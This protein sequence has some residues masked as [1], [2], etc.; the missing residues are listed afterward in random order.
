MWEIKRNF[1]R[2][3]LGYTTHRY[4]QDT[5]GKRDTSEEL[6]EIYRSYYLKALR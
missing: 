5:H 2:H 4:L 1:Y 3:F 6:L